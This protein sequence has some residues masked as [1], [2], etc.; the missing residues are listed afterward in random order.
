MIRIEVKKEFLRCLNRLPAGRKERA[1]GALGRFLSCLEERR[2]P[3]SGL[4][5]KMIRRPYWEFRSGLGDR[6]LFAWSRDLISLLLVGSH[7]DIHRF[8]R[9]R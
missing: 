8:L 9:R 3:P 2:P 5:L 7:D 1:K 6:I 4:G